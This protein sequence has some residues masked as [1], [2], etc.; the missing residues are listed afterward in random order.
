MPA[1]LKSP[2]Q[3]RLNF[4]RVPTY[5]STEFSVGASNR[6]AV[7]RV[8]AWRN[9]HNNSLVLV[10]P[11]SSG[12]THL[13]R[14]WAE[15]VGAKVFPSDTL[16]PLAAPDGPLVLEDVDQGAHPE[17]LFYCLNRAAQSNTPVLLTGRTLPSTWS[18]DLPDL[19]S[20]LNALQVA[21]LLPP[22]DD[23]LRDIL[24]SFFKARNIRPAEDIYPYL[25][26]RM[27]RSIFAAQDLVDRLDE[28]ADALGRPISKALA[29]EVLGADTENLDLFDG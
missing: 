3:M 8:N 14:I 27:Q 18:A 10:G 25:M 17:L 6:D 7:S 11:E 12:K 2:Q 22:D 21:E 16:D 4:R 26:A 29:R 20:R 5:L 28:V 24:R 19:R 13:A 15:T 1:D 9:W 23:V